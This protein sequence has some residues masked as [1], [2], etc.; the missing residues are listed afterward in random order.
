MLT[1]FVDMAESSDDDL[2][3]TKTKKRRYDEKMLQALSNEVASIRE[4]MV[5]MMSLTSMMNLP[6]GLS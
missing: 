2:E 4:M 5:D 6:I 1:S 3:P